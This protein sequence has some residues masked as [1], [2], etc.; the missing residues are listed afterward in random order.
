VSTGAFPKVSTFAPVVTSVAERS[1]TGE[2]ATSDDGTPVVEVT[3]E[4][5]VLPATLPGANVTVA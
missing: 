1:K 5:C 4:T 3:T 2:S